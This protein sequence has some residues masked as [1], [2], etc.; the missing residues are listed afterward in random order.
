MKLFLSNF[1]CWLVGLAAV[2]QVQTVQRLE[3]EISPKRG[4][5]YRV[6]PLGPDGLLTFLESEEALRTFKKE[7]IITKYDTALKVQ[8]AHAH[9]LENESNL[10]MYASQGDWLY[11]L[12][13][14]LE[15]NYEFLKLNTHTGQL[16]VVKYEKI[17]EMEVTHFAVL[18]EVFY[19]GGLVNGTPVV[20]HYDHQHSKPKVLP[21]INQLK[22]AI[23]RID[24]DPPSGT[25]SVILTS[26]VKKKA[27]FYYMVYD[28]AG[29][30]VSSYTAPTEKDYHL[31][32]FRPY[33]LGRNDQI[34]FG[35]YSVSAKDKAQGV[36]VA[37]IKNQEMEQIKVYD[38]SYLKNF[39][40]YLQP[41]KK[42]KMLMRI[43]DQRQDGNPPKYDY[44]FFVRDLQF[45]ADKIIFVA[46]SYVPIFSDGSPNGFARNFSYPIGAW[47]NTPWS[48]MPNGFSYNANYDPFSGR[49]GGGNPNRAPVGYRFKHA[50]VCAFDFQGKLLW[51][52][53]YEYKDLESSQ[54]DQFVQVATDGDALR[55]MHFQEEKLYWKTT[56][57]SLPVDSLQ[58]I[59]VPAK[60]EAEKTISERDREQVHYWYSNC[61][62][63]HGIHELKGVPPTNA[64]PASPADKRKKVFY[65]AKL[66]P[67][68]PKTEQEN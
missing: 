32:T 56:R 41:K 35:L 10:N 19:M 38:F 47:M 24:T 22:A 4:S 52:N 61:F 40:N 23:N 55:M 48:M 58:T 67:G 57:R 64:G 8:W 51:D 9:A 29:K 15:K 37:R 44:N 20:I 62:L 3:V 66:I 18:N 39:F 14:K 60:E 16:D 13:P 21:G 65:L 1:F 46:E 2:A 49:V 27:S 53:S 63:L 7:V 59:E 17:V 30:Q 68:L 45:V 26:D 12:I 54:P 6:M 42:D 43:K 31:F 25:M 50:I 11:F 34:L 28:Q 5:N 33:Y 36:Y